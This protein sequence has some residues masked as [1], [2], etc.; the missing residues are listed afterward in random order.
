[1]GGYQLSLMQIYSQTYVY[2]ELQTEF[3]FKHLKIN[4][5]AP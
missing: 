1:M 3:S 4:Y 5:A 2:E